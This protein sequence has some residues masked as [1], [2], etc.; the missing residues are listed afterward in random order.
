MNSGL[1][2]IPDTMPIDAAAS[3]MVQRGEAKSFGQACNIL[4]AR[5][6]PARYGR[7]EITPA[8]R[9]ARAYVESPRL[10]YADN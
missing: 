8:D 6:R 1:R 4:R 7:T 10:P 3:M 2:P 5:R 9:Q